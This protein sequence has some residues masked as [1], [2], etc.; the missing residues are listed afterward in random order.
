[1]SEPY[2][3]GDGVT[4][5]T[6]IVTPGGAPITGATV[7]LVVTRPDG[8]TLSPAPTVTE[9]PP[10]SG[11][12]VSTAFVVDQA[13]QWLA[14]WTASGTTTARAWSKFL[15]GTD[16]VVTD[17][18]PFASPDD[19]REETGSTA[20]DLPDARAR[21]ILAGVSSRIRDV[22][23]WSISQETGAVFTRDTPCGRDLLLPTLRLTAVTSVVLNGTTLAASEYEWNSTGRLRRL[24]GW[25]TASAEL[26]TVVATVTHGYPVGQIPESVRDTC[27]EYATRRVDTPGGV[28]KGFRIDDYSEN[29]MAVSLTSQLESD[30]RLAAYRLPVVA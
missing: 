10:A 26:R 29:P 15:V 5:T 11:T 19:L 21:R 22:C 28:Q 17:L 1:V 9:T 3:I 2:D 8:T 12:Y 4:L 6:P 13:G 24:A 18:P 27:L 23:G 7:L 30:A 25:Y 14:R 16:P 20:T